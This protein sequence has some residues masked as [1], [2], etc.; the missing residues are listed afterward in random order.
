MNKGT[1][2]LDIYCAVNAIIAEINTIRDAATLNGG[3][4]NAVHGSVYGRVGGTLIGITGILIQ[5]L[6]GSNN[7]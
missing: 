4:Y 2:T 7:G 6:K 3:V 1:V 5:E